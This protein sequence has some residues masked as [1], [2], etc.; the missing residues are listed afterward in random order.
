MLGALLLRVAF[1]LKILNRKVLKEVRALKDPVLVIGNHVSS[2]D[3]LFMS[4]LLFPKRLSFVVARNLYYNDSSSWAL[5]DNE[6]LHTQKAVCRR[7]RVRKVDKEDD[8]QGHKR[9]ALPPREGCR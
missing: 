3:F 4:Y 8:R 7:L 1:R 5:R 6:K 2:I 9:G